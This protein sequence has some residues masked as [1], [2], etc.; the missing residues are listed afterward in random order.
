MGIPFIAK[1]PNFVRN[2]VFFVVEI[3]ELKTQLLLSEASTFKDAAY[4][5]T[6]Q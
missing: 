3:S 2:S 4:I 1:T 5:I 6:C